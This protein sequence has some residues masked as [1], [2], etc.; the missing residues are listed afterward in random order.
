MKLQLSGDWESDDFGGSTSADLTT[1]I[2][3]PFADGYPDPKKGW[4]FGGMLGLAIASFDTP[5]GNDG[6]DGFGVGGAAWA[7]YDVWV[8]PEWSI[9]GAL[10]INA[11]R[12]TDSDDDLTISSIGAQFAVSVLLH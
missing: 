2:V 1:L 5:G 4:H 3:G 10:K 9:G 8:A 6:S 12:A 11:L 7:G